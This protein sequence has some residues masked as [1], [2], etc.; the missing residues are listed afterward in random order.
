M[1]PSL[2]GRGTK[3]LIGVDYSDGYSFIMQI[4]K[5]GY[6]KI[7]CKFGEASISIRKIKRIDI[8]L[9]NKSTMSGSDINYPVIL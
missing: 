1:D 4:S 6:T 3:T 2:S 9:L 8:I 7:A 5:V